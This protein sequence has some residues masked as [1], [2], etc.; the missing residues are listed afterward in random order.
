MM[1]RVTVRMRAQIQV[2]ASRP[3]TAERIACHVASLDLERRARHHEWII[4]DL[5][6]EWIID[7]M[8]ADAVGPGGEER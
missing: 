8:E 6:Q 3:E 5:H 2:D 7:W 4:D 1:V